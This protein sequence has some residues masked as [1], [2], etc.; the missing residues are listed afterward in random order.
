RQQQLA[1]VI[2]RDADVDSL[3][4]FIGVDGT[5]VTLNSGRFLINLKPHDARTA[6][7]ATI[8][9]RLQRETANVA[10][11]ALY[12]QPVQDLSIE[13]QVSATEYQFALDDQDLATLQAWTPKVLD[14][15]AKVAEIVDVASD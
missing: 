2:L 11:I 5:N 3:S 10:G 4:S 1:A 13:T 8:I 15:L 12:M 6:D 7:V 14:R 9:R